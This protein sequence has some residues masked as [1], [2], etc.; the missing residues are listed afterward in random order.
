[1]GLKVRGFEFG[2]LG[3]MDVDF[4]FVCEGDLHIKFHGHGSIYMNN[5]V[6]S[7]KS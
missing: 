4:E 6:D 1:M 3:F 2:N 7:W 5:P